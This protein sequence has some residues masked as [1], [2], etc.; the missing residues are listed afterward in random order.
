M[1]TSGGSGSGL[2]SQTC[3]RLEREL[4]MLREQR[5]ALLS[6]PDGRV[7][8][9]DRADNAEAL[10]RSDEAA[11]LDERI[12]GITRLLLGAPAHSAAPG[13]LPSGSLITLRFDDGAVEKLRAVAIPEE[14]PEGE[15]D[16]SLTLDSPLGR[17][18]AGHQPGDTVSWDTPDGMR[19]AELLAIEPPH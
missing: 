17:A 6:G 15:E 18:V 14:V 7:E 11:L 10:R 9:G 12:A 16:S 19:Q 8:L 13:K 3:Q 5:D 2:S 4:A 1:S